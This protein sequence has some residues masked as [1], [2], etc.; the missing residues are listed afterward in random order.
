MKKDG[1]NIIVS[2]APDKVL[3]ADLKNKQACKDYANCI[4]G[5]FQYA[6]KV[7]SIL[8]AGGKVI[9]N[10]SAH[11]W[12]GYPDSCLIYYKD[13][14][15]AVKRLLTISAAELPKVQW[16]IS[17]VGLLELYNPTAEG[18]A[19]FSKYG[20]IYDYSDVLRRTN[21]TVI[22]VK[23]GQVYGL[24]LANMTGDEVNAYCKKQ[25]LQ[26]AVMLDGGHVA[27]I[28]CEIGQAN[29]KQ[30]Q[31]NIIQFVTDNKGGDNVSKKKVCIDAGHGGTDPGAVGQNG[32]KE[33]DVALQ[34]ALLV[35][36]ALQRCGIEVMHT[37]DTDKYMSL[38]ER[39]AIANKAGADAFVSVHCNS[40]TNAAAQGTETY[41]F[42]KQSKGY[43]LA[44]MVHQELI[45]VT[46]TVDRGL[47]TKNYAVLR[48]TGMAAALVELGFISN[49]QEEKLLI[50]KSWQKK[51]A[52]A[53]AKGIVQYLGMVWMPAVEEKPAYN[54]KVIA[55][56]GSETLC[57]IE[58]EN[59][60]GTVWAPVRQLAEA[61]GCRVGYEEKEKC[62]VVHR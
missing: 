56:D 41:A 54:L 10:S 19:R 62:V 12:L 25:G 43:P 39:A 42:S 58:Q 33:K 49:E 5:T 32:T 59:R 4:S 8:V 30:K 6:G 51:V 45:A 21:H 16:A 48:E 3:F 57:Q 15:F 2:A 18:Y 22:G 20:K 38:S 44:K 24:Y 13:G 60:N 50:N 61:L 11:A 27:A 29:A 52:E 34:I 40:A 7:C 47:K 9:N 17:G 1:N 14:A 31:S 37:R 36:D 46:G 26:Y 23:G 53:I 28:N 55:A 35:R